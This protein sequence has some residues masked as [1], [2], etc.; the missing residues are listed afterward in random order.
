MSTQEEKI[1]AVTECVARFAEVET[2]AETLK[3]QITALVDAING[4]YSV[5]VG[6]Q[7]EFL[8]IVNTLEAARGD[9]ASAITRVIA[10]HEKCTAIAKRE[11]C[12]VALPDAFAITGGV[13]AMGGTGR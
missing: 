4:A 6:R 13:T 12:D 5:G 10:A 7:G 11:D 2:G 9:V 1:A 8:R 3:D